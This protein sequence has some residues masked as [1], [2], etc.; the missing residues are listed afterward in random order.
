MTNQN[1][2]IQNARESLIR[3]D[4]YCKIIRELFIFLGCEPFSENFLNNSLEDDIRK[5]ISRQESKLSSLIKKEAA[6][7]ES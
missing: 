6:E 2:R 3:A 5:F 1:K 4:V 7:N